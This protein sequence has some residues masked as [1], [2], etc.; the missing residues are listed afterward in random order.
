MAARRLFFD[1]YRCL[2][3]EPDSRGWERPLGAKR[4]SRLPAW[5]LGYL[6]RRVLGLRGGA[7]V[8]QVGLWSIR[9]RWAI[10]LANFGFLQVYLAPWMKERLRLITI[11]AGSKLRTNRDFNTM[12]SLEGFMYMRR[13]HYPKA[14]ALLLLLIG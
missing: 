8:P 7:L 14:H 6:L 11:T 9:G 2:S 10:F 1:V 3:R 12:I 5:C 4:A 13:G